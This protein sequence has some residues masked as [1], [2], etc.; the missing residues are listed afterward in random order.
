MSSYERG[1]GCD[2]IESGICYSSKEEEE[3]NR[4]GG[5][6]SQAMDAEH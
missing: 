1:A 3:E 4:A 2:A 6:M 5:G